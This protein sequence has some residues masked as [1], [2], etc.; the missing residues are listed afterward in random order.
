[1]YPEYLGTWNTTVAGYRHGFATEA[2]H[3][4]RAT[5]RDCTV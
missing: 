1:M 2:R 3:Q 5:T 4:E